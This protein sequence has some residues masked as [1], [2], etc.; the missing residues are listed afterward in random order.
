MARQKEP[1]PLMMPV[2]HYRDWQR[3]VPGL[4]GLYNGMR[5]ILEAELPEAAEVLIVGAG[6]GREIE[7]LAASPRDFR[8][9]GI[10]P[11]PEMLALAAQF[12]GAARVTLV[13]G[14]V[15][16]LPAER[17]FDAATSLLVMHFLPGLA[18]KRAYLRSIRTRLRPGAP[19]LHADVSLE[20]AAHFARLAPAFGSHARLMGFDDS[21]AEGATGMLAQMTDGRAISEAATLNLFGECGFRLVSPFFRGLWYAGWWAE[22][23]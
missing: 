1:Q 17:L 11:S 6:G 20:G 8:L 4:D 5:A 13:Q 23:A 3:V 12:A 9:S 19:Y 2:A 14:V 15:D 16:D 18:E 10:D 7:Q 22:A 21:F